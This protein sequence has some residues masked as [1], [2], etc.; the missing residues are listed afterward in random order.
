MVEATEDR[1]PH[2]GLCVSTPVRYST[3]SS[4]VRSP[5]TSS[6]NVRP[7]ERNAVNIEPLNP[8]STAAQ[9]LIA[10][11][12]V[13]LAAL[14]PAE[15]NHIES[16]QALALPSALFLGGYIAG[17]L[18]ACG[19]VKTITEDGTYGEIKR[20]FV[21]ESHRGKGL[22][23]AIMRRLEAHLKASGV[24]IARL[25][26]GIKQ[27]ESLGLYK[28]LAYVERGPFGNYSSDPLSVFME[29][30]LEIS[31]ASRVK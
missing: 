29:K 14:Y 12:D 3:P 4:H 21:L 26:T 27:P 17:E 15:S 9:A 20:V 8:K 13:Y 22:S 18:V 2:S 10:K 6:S 11:S 1:H 16:I 30:R 25:E 23:K 28:R 7:H 19:A 5:L 31:Q 24:R